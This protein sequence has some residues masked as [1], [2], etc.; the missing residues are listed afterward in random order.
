MSVT[1]VELRW[2]PTCGKLPSRLVG[3]DD[4]IFERSGGFDEGCGR[5]LNWIVLY[6]IT[7]QNIRVESFHQ[8]W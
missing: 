8:L 1:L 6:E 5:T 3:E 4:L 7:D 2:R